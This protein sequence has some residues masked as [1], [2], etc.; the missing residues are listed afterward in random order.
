MADRTD[1]T[2]T[3]QLLGPVTQ[4]DD[5]RLD[6]FLEQMETIRTAF[7]ETERLIWHRDP[8]LY[9]RI[10][11]L[12]KNS[13][14]LVVLEAVSDEVDERADAAYASY[15][16][17]SLTTNLRII[18]KKKRLPSKMDLPTVE[19]YRE[20]AIP[21]EKHRLQIQI[22]AG[23]HTADLNPSF[24]QILEQAIGRDEFSY[25]S[26]SGTLEEIN[27][28][29]ENRFRLYP[30]VGP[31]RIIG[32]FR[33]KDRK[34]FTAALDKYVTVYGRLRYKT[35]EDFPHQVNADDVQI[36][37]IEIPTLLDLKGA[38]PGATGDLTTQEYLDHLRDEH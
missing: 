28:H 11:E 13:P 33:S 2:I 6:D 27:L 31:T 3:I 30:T 18:S 5:L 9:L 8:S 14:A 19:A 38:S 25:G 10:K 24:R 4:G 7:R 22:R 1:R 37:D 29:G 20:L 26:I 34:K 32:Y 23:N 36:H 15:V 35:W 21:L 12:R 17:R 16:V